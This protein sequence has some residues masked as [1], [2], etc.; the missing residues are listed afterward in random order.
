MSRS[1]WRSSRSRRPFEARSSSGRRGAA[2][3]T[4]FI[5]KGEGGWTWDRWR[6]TLGERPPDGPVEWVAS[7]KVA[8]EIVAERN[9]SLGLA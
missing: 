6:P 2:E 3:T 4:C 7:E 9:R 8:R 5:R 1:S